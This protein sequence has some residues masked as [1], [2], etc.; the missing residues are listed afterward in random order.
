VGMF[1]LMSYV[2]RQRRH[3]LGV[4]LALGATPASLTRLVVERGMRYA[5][6]GSGIGLLLGLLQAHW[7]GPLLYEVQAVDPRA[8]V[9]AAAAMLAVAALA[10]GLPGLAAAR[11]HPVEALSSG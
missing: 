9:L 6:L 11:V 5:A 1:G 8:F 10:C 2:V 4:R 7:L 3:E